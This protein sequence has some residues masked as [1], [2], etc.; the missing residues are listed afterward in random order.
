MHDLPIRNVHTF[1]FDGRCFAFNGDSLCVAE[2]NSTLKEALDLGAT[3]RSVAALIDALEH[4]VGR[5]E[6]SRI[7]TLLSHLE[8]AGFFNAPSAE[9]LRGAAEALL[10]EVTP[11]AGIIG[12]DLLVTA[13]CNLRCEY[14]YAAHGTLGLATQ[15]PFITDQTFSSVV[16]Y[17]KRSARSTLDVALL[18]GEPLLHPRAPWLLDTLCSSLEEH[19]IDISV[20]VTTNGTV[21]SQAIL[22]ALR[23]NGVYL[24]ISMDGFETEHD[25][26]RRMVDG[27]GSFN[28]IMRNL[29]RYANE[30]GT[31]RLS[32]R[33][34]A[35]RHNV[36]SL[37]KWV[38]YLR[39]RFADIKIR[40]APV[41]TE[42][43]ACCGF[44]ESARATWVSAMQELQDREIALDGPITKLSKDEVRKALEAHR[45]YRRQRLLSKCHLGVNQVA[46]T[47]D[48]SLYPCAGLA[49]N[50]RYRLGDVKSGATEH[51]LI[52]EIAAT[53]VVTEREECHACWAKYL[54]AGG[55]VAASE[56]F[57]GQPF[58]IQDAACWMYRAQAE[59]LLR[60]FVTTMKCVVGRTTFV[61]HMC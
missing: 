15:V 37:L 41:F 40:C 52:R 25:R 55:C 50:P 34:T 51:A 12:V 57:S 49:G 56:K 26:Q 45:L 28:L 48:G 13:E 5:E 23:R 17:L 38:G 24:S 47:T 35:T 27:R 32:V 46:I 21:I 60:A 20:G 31:D 2:V 54:C 36:A 18:G 6:A 39:D 59:L 29:E 43:E 42:P 14:C 16:D 8:A 33:V 10:A 4:H 44:D 1:Q 61:D 30:L 22:D 53:N 3:E 58:A 19:G 7:P 9:Q 11:E